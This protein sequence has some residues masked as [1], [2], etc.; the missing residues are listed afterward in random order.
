M[1]KLFFVAMAMFAMMSCGGNKTEQ[2]AAVDSDSVAV[3]S[4][5]ADT[6]VVADSVSAE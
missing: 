1:K 3:D 2:G 4:V 5:V 6:I